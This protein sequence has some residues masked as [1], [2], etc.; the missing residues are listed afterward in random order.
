MDEHADRAGLHALPLQRVGQCAQRHGQGR[1]RPEQL[2]AP[3]DAGHGS[4]RETLVHIMSAQWIWLARWNGTS[5]GSMLASAEFLD[6]ESIRR[7]WGQ[8]DG[9]TRR[10]VTTRSEEELTRSPG[11]LDLLVFV[12]ESG[13][14]A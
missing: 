8:I 11:D 3:G 12:D 7:R 14:G 13:A 1:L 2:A 6:L 4:V 5:P 10:F 9:D